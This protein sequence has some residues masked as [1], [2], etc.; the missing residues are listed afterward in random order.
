MKTKY[1][2]VICFKLYIIKSV[3]KIKTKGERI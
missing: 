3:V 1:E 2:K